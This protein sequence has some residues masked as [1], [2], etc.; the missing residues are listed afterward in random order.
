VNRKR[1]ECERSVW[2]FDIN[3]SEKKMKGKK[4]THILLND[5]STP[6]L[7]YNILLQLY[8]YI[9]YKWKKELCPCK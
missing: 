3:E 6:H 4:D 2:L 9:Y 7:K 1:V 5:T 8:K